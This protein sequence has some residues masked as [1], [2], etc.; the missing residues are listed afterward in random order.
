MCTFVP[1]HVPDDLF[2]NFLKI[3]I[4]ILRRIVLLFYH[5]PGLASHMPI[6]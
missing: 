6:V 1:G 2:N 3:G 4:N 5:G